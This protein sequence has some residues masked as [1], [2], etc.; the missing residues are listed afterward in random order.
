MRHLV[1]PGPDPDSITPDRLHQAIP[2]SN[3]SIAQLAHTLNTT[4]AHAIYLLA[5]HPVDWSPPRL[6]RTQQTATH[7]PQ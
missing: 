4:T 5:Q 1:L 3:F 2:G 7:V 6:R